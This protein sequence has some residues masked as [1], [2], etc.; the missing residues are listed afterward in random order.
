MNRVIKVGES[1]TRFIRRKMQMTEEKV[2]KAQGN[3]TNNKKQKSGRM[4]EEDR[5]SKREE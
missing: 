2:R 3:N 5:G 4:I 1:S